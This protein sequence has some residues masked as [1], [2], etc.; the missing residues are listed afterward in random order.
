MERTGQVG[1]INPSR[2]GFSNSIPLRMSAVALLSAMFLALTGCTTTASFLAPDEDSPPSGTVTRIT[3]VWN[4]EV[5]F[6]ADPTHNGAKKPGIAGRLYLFGKDMKYPLAAEGSLM[7]DLYDDGPADSGQDPRMIEEWRIDNNTL[8]RLVARDMIGWG[9]TL[10]LPWGSYKPEITR[11]HLAI[12]FQPAE[13]TKP[14]AAK[15]SKDQATPRKPSEQPVVIVGDSLVLT[16]P[17]AGMNHFSTV[18]NTTEPI[19]LPPPSMGLGPIP[20]Q[21]PH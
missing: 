6:V 21:Q 10:F 15:N 18:K 14:Q 1:S 17:G 20:I 8:Q 5:A 4:N 11:V 19:Q 7:V 9:Y 16:N 2:R 13:K 3:A 12:R